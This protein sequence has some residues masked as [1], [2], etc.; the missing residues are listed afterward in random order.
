MLLESTGLDGSNPAVGE[1]GLMVEVSQALRLMSASMTERTRS[2]LT[3]E[4]LL[5]LR[6]E[7]ASV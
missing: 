1:L 6:G 4:H 3:I 2:T 5:V 7:R